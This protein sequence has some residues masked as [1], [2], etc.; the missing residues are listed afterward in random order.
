MA[1]YP[2]VAVNPP[3]LDDHNIRYSI[4][5]S[6]QAHCLRDVHDLLSARFRQNPWGTTKRRHLLPHIMNILT[7]IAAGNLIA[8]IT[9]IVTY[10]H[11]QSPLFPQLPDTKRYRNVIEKLGNYHANLHDHQKWKAL[12]FVVPDI[13]VPELNDMNWTVSNRSYNRAMVVLGG[14]DGNIDM[15]STKRYDRIYQ[16]IND[17]LQKAIY[18]HYLLNSRSSPNI[19]LKKLSEE[20]G[21]PVVKRYMTCSIRSAWHTFPHNKEVKLTSFQK[22]RPPEFGRPKRD[23]DKCSYC[24]EYHFLNHQL[25]RLYET[26]LTGHPEGHQPR[27][28]GNDPIVEDEVEKNLD[29]EGDYNPFAQRHDPLDTDTINHILEYINESIPNENDAD[30]WRQRIASYRLA[31]I[32]RNNSKRIQQKFNDKLQS[33]TIHEL[34]FVFDYKQNVI[35]GRCPEEEHWEFR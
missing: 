6:H 2:L 29:D 26:I 15:Q 13:T 30:I 19:V 32:H 17:D 4:A 28:L 1:L 11:R 23:S 34:L 24:V 35:V 33:L 18:E 27:N 21:Y 12:Q 31:L 10:S 5:G 25:H 8:L 16:G 22:Y 7:V 9:D 20:R 3:S 14:N